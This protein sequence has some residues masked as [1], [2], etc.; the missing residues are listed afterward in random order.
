MILSS[1]KMNT[2]S[3]NTTLPLTY[4]ICNKSEPV[5]S[6]ADIE[7][8]EYLFVL[9]ISVPVINITPE[10]C[11]T[12]IRLRTQNCSVEYQETSSDKLNH[13]NKSRVM[14]TIIHF[15]HSLRRNM[16]VELS[17]DTMIDSYNDYISSKVL[18]R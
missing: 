5:H 14:L 15:S 9:V 7:I 3:G 6:D 17:N 10:N 12:E 1:L 8:P 18:R 16:Y 11:S 4:G 2:L 13:T